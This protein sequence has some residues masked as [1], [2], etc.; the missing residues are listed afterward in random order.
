MTDWYFYLSNLSEHVYSAVYS[1]PP[2]PRSSL[3]PLRGS[4]IHSS[5]AS[6]ASLV[7]SYGGHA[8]PLFYLLLVGAYL[9]YLL[10]SRVLSVGRNE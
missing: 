3:R 1:Y 6:P 2:L 4:A 10:S 7:H 5:A 8:R 9:P